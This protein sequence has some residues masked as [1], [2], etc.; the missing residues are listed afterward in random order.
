MKAKLKTFS[1]FVKSLMP[2]E[3][4]YLESVARFKDETNRSIFEAIIKFKTTGKL[5]LN[6][7]IDKRKYTYLKNWIYQNLSAIDVDKM[8]EDLLHLEKIVMT[9][10]VL[11]ADEKRIIKIIKTQKKL[12]YY[13]M[14]IYELIRDFRSFLLVRMRYHYL[15]PVNSY[16]DQ[17]QES[18]NTS[19]EVFENL[20]RATRDITDQYT[21]KA[22]NASVW[23]DFLK[24]V[25]YNEQLD[26]LNRYYAIVRLTF[27]HY[28][29]N[30]LDK[31]EDL[32]DYLNHEFEMGKFYSRRI[33]SNY[34]SNR[35]LLHAKMN[36]PELA[37]K[38]GYLS[39]RDHG[40]DYVHY[41]NNH[42]SVLLR[43]KKSETALQLLQ[44]SIPELKKTMSYHNRVGFAS[45]FIKSLNANGK[46]AEGESYGTTFFTAY[47]EKVLEYRW[48]SFFSAWL[49]SMIMQEKYGKVLTVCR[50]NKIP[51]MEIEYSK[52]P[53]YLPTISWY[54]LL[55]RYKSGEIDFDKLKTE[56]EKSGNEWG[57]KQAINELVNEISL[58]IPELLFKKK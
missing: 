29:N 45:I 17:Y 27:L 54:Y 8:L 28:N 12:P 46:A 43:L 56:I 37:E 42:C 4:T 50:R 35:L 9:D 32:Y 36:K 38:Y 22:N 16:L 47:K 2:L 5:K 6:P 10:Q 11:P 51:E 53:G 18:Y 24:D 34:Y 40:S 30:Q 31:I 49:Q 44:K 20:N 52:K 23:E 13:F 7:D 55:S 39:L 33:L 58:H 26:G 41:L 19:R 25:F 14:R 57:Q 15:E 3:I 1:E 21:Q 48:H